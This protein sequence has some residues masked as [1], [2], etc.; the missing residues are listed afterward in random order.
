MILVIST[1]GPLA[2]V[3]YYDAGGQL[4]GSASIEANRQASGAILKLLD[5]IERTSG[6]SASDARG[7]VADI[8]PGSFTGVKVGVTIVKSFGLG[9]DKQVA[10]IS[11]FD[12]IATDR[13][14]AIANVSGRFFVRHPGDE[15]YLQEGLPECDFVGY[16][17]GLEKAHYPVAANAGVTV[18][19]LVW[20]RP[21]ALVPLYIAEPSISTPKQAYGSLIPGE[22]KK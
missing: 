6:L 10:G 16:G 20:M 12:L 19:N 21:E 22:A 3:A 4:L 17:K 1:S 2:S 5:E 9:F 18:A 8:G 15:G 13:V 14:V 7:F 11:S